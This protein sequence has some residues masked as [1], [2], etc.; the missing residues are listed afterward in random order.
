MSI[1]GVQV[2]LDLREPHTHRVLVTLSASAPAEHFVV[3]LPGWTPGSYLIRDYVRQLEG[4]SAEQNGRVLALTRLSP[5]RW[6]VE[7][8]SPHEPV[9]IRYG[10]MATELSVRTCH[11]DQDHGFF[12][13]AAVVLELEGQR[14]QPHQLTCQLPA[15]WQAFTP[16]AAA[17]DGGWLARDYDQLID[18][19]LEVGAHTLHQFQVRGV[20]HRWVT[21]AGDARDA[22]W[23]HERYP[24]F[25]EDVRRVCEACCDLLAESAPAS[26]DY[27]FVLHLLDDGYGGLEHDDS[28]VLVYGRRNLEAEHGY[29]KLLQLIA[30]EYFHQWNVRR[31]TPAE[32]RPIDYQQASVV[33]TLWFAEG[34][35]SYVDQWLPLRAGLSEPEDYL[36]DLGEDLSRYLLSPGRFVQS[37]QTSSEEAWVKLYKPDAY[38]GNSQISYYLKGA[39][40]ALCADLHLRQ[41]GSSLERVLQGLWRSHGAVGRGYQQQD[42]LAAF[43]AACAGL[44]SILERWLTSVDDPDIDGYLLSVGLALEP[45]MAAHPWSGAVL[46]VQ[47]NGLQVQRIWRQ[48][49]AERAGLMVGDELIGLD[50]TRLT[51]VEQWERLLSAGASHELL[52]SRR[53]QLRRLRLEPGAPAVKRYRLVTLATARP[54]QEA[55]RAAW[56]RPA[57]R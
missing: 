20:P 53:S 18:S 22:S 49:P 8:A 3:S 4:L 52:I 40:I 41:N 9:S 14:W 19:P 25:F 51:L 43:E 26:R 44:G 10:V 32:L 36:H 56:L 31:L 15:Q 39:V 42:L 27:L 57:G 33:P 47:P 45:E 38:S 6:R 30:H 12:A 11:F 17:A 54:E 29:R 13:L 35:T 7:G 21:W 1:P 23:F 5:S 46:K 34:V 2:H 24:S 37:L 50:A 16:L 55:A 48:S 28:C